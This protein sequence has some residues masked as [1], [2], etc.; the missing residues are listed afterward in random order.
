MPPKASRRSSSVKNDRVSV[1]GKLICRF[2]KVVCLGLPVLYAIPTAPAL[3]AEL[4]KKD[5]G[6]LE[7][8][9]RLVLY[10]CSPVSGDLTGQ[11]LNLESQ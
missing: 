10:L 2:Y 1:D 3:E 4:R 11:V 7:R 9:I 8:L 5:P 6:L